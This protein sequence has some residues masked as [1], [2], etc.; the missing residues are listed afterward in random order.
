KAKGCGG[1]LA[2]AVD[3]QECRGLER[4]W[5]ECGRSMRFMMAGKNEFCIIAKVRQ[6]FPNS[7]LDFQLRACPVR[8][9]IHPAAESARCAMERGAD[10][11]FQFQKGLII[12]RNNVHVPRGN[13]AFHQ[14]KGDSMFGERRIVL[15]SCKALLFRSCNDSPVCD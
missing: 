14:N 7:T 6:G 5:I 11:P 10:D 13:S 15:A 9:D 4:R 1:P 2:Y 3:R 12:E 8:Q